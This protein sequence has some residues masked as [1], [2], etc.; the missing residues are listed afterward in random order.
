MGEMPLAYAATHGHHQNVTAVAPEKDDVNLRDLV[1]RQRNGNKD[2]LHGEREA[3]L[4]Q[5]ENEA[6]VATFT[7]ISLSANRRLRAL[8]KSVWHQR[9]RDHFRRRAL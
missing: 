1:S 9:G 6:G 5:R 2:A 4:A 8:P 3:R 7:R